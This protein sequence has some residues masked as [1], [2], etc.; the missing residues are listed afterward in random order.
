MVRRLRR[1]DV[2]RVA[3][4]QVFGW[5]TTFRGIMSDELLF[6]ERTV[7]KWLHLWYGKVVANSKDI[8]DFVFAE[9]GH[10]KGVVTCG[11]CR[12]ED[13]VGAYELWGLYVEPCMKGGGI[14]TKLVEHCENKAREMGCKEFVIWAVEEN[15]RAIEFYVK[16]FGYKLDGTK[17]VRPPVVVPQVRMVK[18]LS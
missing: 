2:A 8:F 11:F 6:N 3:E 9:D 15:V 18:K 1:E 4:I 5:R 13:K 12:D 16:K 7:E 17:K 10:V 14:G